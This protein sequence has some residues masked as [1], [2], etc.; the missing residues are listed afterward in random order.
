[1]SATRLPTRLEA[2]IEQA[3]DCERA[4]ALL[5]DLH[6]LTATLRESARRDNIPAPLIRPAFY[7]PVSGAKRGRDS[8]A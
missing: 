2:L 8:A 4:R 6:H 3:R 7:R 5:A 1:M